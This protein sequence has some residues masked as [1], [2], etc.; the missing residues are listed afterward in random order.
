MNETRALFVGRFN[1]FHLG[2]LQVVQKILKNEDELI[3]AIGST[4]QSH[5]LTDPF[6]AG[7]RVLM[8]RECLKEAN[9]SLEKVFILTIPDIF[10]NSVWVS[11]L[12]SYCPPFNS[13]YTNSSLIR[14][15]FMDAGIT[16]KSAGL[17]DRKH[18][19]GSY[20]R[21]LMLKGEEWQ[22]LVP[23]AVFNVIK[24]IN[25]VQRLQNIVQGTD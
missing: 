4:Q 2:H 1:P 6:T 14:Q 23:L 10:R 8:I 11:H 19:K 25:G 3:I 21:Q 16:V 15:L 22:L 7:E 17:F 12:Q 9:I 5:T 24:S 20:I 18:L 13:V